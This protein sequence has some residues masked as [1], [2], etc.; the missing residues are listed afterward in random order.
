MSRTV[1]EVSLTTKAGIGEVR[2]PAFDQT[3]CG[4]IPSLGSLASYR[5]M[6]VHS[7]MESRSG[8]DQH[9]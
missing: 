1:P 7:L 2:F 8:E 4:A 6:Q 9:A 5:L 3:K